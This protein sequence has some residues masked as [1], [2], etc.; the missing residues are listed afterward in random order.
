MET[1]TGEDHSVVENPE[2]MTSPTRPD[3]IT[4]TDRLIE[5][6]HWPFASTAIV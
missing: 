3:E 5:N 6:F 1:N 4:A 2:A